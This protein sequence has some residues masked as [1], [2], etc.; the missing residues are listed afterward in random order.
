MLTY[1]FWFFIFGGSGLIYQVLEN[2]QETKMKKLE[3]R[4]RELKV[5]ELKAMNM[6]TFGKRYF[7][8]EQKVIDGVINS[9]YEEFIPQSQ[10]E[11]NIL[12]DL[13]QGK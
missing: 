4:E 5:E 12:R 8:V 2:I 1:L 3:L 9:D 7:E 11:K 10:A 6:A 13:E